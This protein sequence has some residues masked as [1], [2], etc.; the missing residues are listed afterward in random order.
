M[1]TLEDWWEPPLKAATNQHCHT[2]N[3]FSGDSYLNEYLPQNIQMIPPATRQG[4]GR[5]SMNPQ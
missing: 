3:N 5:R 4:E 1:A 2:E